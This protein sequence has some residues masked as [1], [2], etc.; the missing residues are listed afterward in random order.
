M[1]KFLRKE[2]GGEDTR[3][4]KFAMIIYYS[5]IIIAITVFISAR[6]ISKTDDVLKSKVSELTAALNVQMKM[7]IESYLEKVETTATLIFAEK[8]VYIYDATDES[9]DE[10]ESLSTENY[11]SDKLYSLCIMENFVDF[12]IVYSNDHIVGKMSNNTKS[13]FGTRLYEDLSA[14]INRERTHDGWAAGYNDDYNRIYYVKRVNDNAVLVTSFYTTELEDVFEHP[15]EI[16]DITIR[17]VESGNVVIYSS[18]R[19]ETGLELTEDIGD[20]IAQHTAVTLMDDEYLI[21]VNQCG[22]NWKVICSVPT[23]IILKEKN[24][25]QF[26]TLTIAAIAAII[27]IVLS[28]ILSFGVSSS[29]DKTVNVL[30]RKARI[31]MLTG[32]LNKKSFEGMV[33]TTVKRAAENE[34]YALVLFD[35][36]NFKGVNDNFGH[37]SGDKILAG[38]GDVMRRTFR[39]DD[40]LGRVGGDEFCVLMNLTDVKSDAAKVVGKKCSDLG[41][42]VENLKIEDA[43]DCRVSA[44]I[45]VAIYPKHAKNFSELYRSADKALYSSKSKGKNTFTIYSEDMEVQRREKN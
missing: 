45:G 13:L 12:S 15:G 6:T 38:V 18:E 4:F 25:I 14:M 22:D 19:E 21:T 29:V 37:A 27:A 26:Y 17:L 35:I 28:I 16:E 41:A 30:K 42:A 40:L 23:K 43:P 8:E 34:R 10:Y 7:N 9:N 1:A 2:N 24:E 32:L 5:V 11:I 44:S 3:R 39:T 33:D 36:D 31:D 20:R